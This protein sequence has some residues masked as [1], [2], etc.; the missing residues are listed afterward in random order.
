MIANSFKNE[1]IFLM[2]KNSSFNELKTF[3][4]GLSKNDCEYL[5]SDK[6]IKRKYEKY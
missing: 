2:K 6:H 1:L 4:D 3:I 5:L